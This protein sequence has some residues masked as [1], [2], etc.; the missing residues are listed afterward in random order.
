MSRT[1]ETESPGKHDGRRRFG[2]VHC[3]GCIGLA[4]AFVAFGTLVTTYDFLSYEN[5]TRDPD[6]GT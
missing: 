1:R 3:I 2:C 6:H 4:M 5:Y